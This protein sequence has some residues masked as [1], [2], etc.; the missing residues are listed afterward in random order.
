MQVTAAMT[1]GFRFRTPEAAAEAARRLSAAGLG[2]TTHG[3]YES[4]QHD[5]PPEHQEWVASGTVSETR[6]VAEVVDWRSAAGAA[7]TAEL[8]EE[9]DRRAVEVAAL[10]EDLRP[11]GSR[12]SSNYWF[13]D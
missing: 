13:S 1:F 11:H 8:D 6:A 12:R 2:G 9:R 3:R 7:L 5:P 10:V 4:P